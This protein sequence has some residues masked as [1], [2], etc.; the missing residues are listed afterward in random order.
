MYSSEYLVEP[1]LLCFAGYCL[2][3]PPHAG[4]GPWSKT[5]YKSSSCRTLQM[6][7]VYDVASKDNRAT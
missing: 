3:N 2:D 4:G 1:E 6:R 5:H 7:I